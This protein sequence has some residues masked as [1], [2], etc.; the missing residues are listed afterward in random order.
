[1]RT[2]GEAEQW[3]H[4]SCRLAAEHITWRS[5]VANDLQKR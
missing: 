1:V 2:P 3:R 4:A 5:T